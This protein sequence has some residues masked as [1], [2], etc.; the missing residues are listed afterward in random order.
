MQIWGLGSAPGMLASFA[1]STQAGKANT[2]LT[3]KLAKPLPG[4]Q[5]TLRTGYSR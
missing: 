1:D 4:A 5:R 3:Q 2:V